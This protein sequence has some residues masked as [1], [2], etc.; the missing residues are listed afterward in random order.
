MLEK[1]GHSV[2]ITKNGSLAVDAYKARVR[3]NQPFNIILVCQICLRSTRIANV[4][5]DGRVNAF[6][7]WHGGGG[8]HTSI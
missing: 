3:R 2:E 7:G 6:D 5:S 1:Y 4:T 8:A